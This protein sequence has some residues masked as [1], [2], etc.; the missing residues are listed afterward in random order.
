MQYRKSRAS[1]WTTRLFAVCAEAHPT[2]VLTSI[3]LLYSSLEK[4]GGQFE[5]LT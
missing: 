4:S 1:F 5:R 3:V 2:N